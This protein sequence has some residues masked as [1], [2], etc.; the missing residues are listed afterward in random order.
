MSAPTII[1]LRE[2]ED[3]RTGFGG[4]MVTAYN[5]D[6]NTYEEVML[7]LMT[8]T[9]CSSDEAYIETWEIDHLGKSVVH[10]GCETECQGVAAVIT[11]IGLHTEV[12]EA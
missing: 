7:I 3:S 12:S 8:A 11:S 10:Q 5:N 1:P 6:H 9:G 2:F 4:W